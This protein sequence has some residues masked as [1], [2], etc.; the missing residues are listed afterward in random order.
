MKFIKQVKAM[1]KPVYTVLKEAKTSMEE[2]KSIFICSI[3]RITSEQEAMEFINS[4]KT[5]HKDATHN[6]YAYITNNGI[7]MRYSDDGEPQGTAGPP[8]LEVL[9]REGVNDVAAVVTR[10]FGGTLLGAGG[11]IR[12]YSSSCKQGLY[13]AVKVRTEKGISFTMSFDYD[14]YGRIN[15]YL[16]SK[17][18]IIN[19][20]IYLEKISIDGTCLE[21]DYSSM[22]QDMREMFNGEECLSIKSELICFVDDEG[23]IMEV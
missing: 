11:L 14:R 5:Q 17:N 10:Y 12:A 6:V 8:M 13:E 9:K 22:D 2:K 1:D 7:S 21:K 15:N 23:R 20:T 3:K 16:K 18:I 4:I 19:D